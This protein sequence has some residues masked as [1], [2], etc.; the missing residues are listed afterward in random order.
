MFP[1]EI[2]K[3]TKNKCKRKPTSSASEYCYKYNH[4]TKWINEPFGMRVSVP[5]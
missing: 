5:K 1:T 4:Q 3:T 2:T